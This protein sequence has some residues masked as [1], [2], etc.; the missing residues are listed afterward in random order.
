MFAYSSYNPTKK[1]VIL[2]TILICFLDYFFA[3]AAG[4]ICFGAI[5]AAKILNLEEQ[6]QTNG[7]GL[8]FVLFPALASYQEGKYKNEFGLFCFFLFLAGIDS[9]AAFMEALI[10]NVVEQFKWNRTISAL[11]VCL[12]GIGLSAIFCCSFG[13][14][15]FDLVEH[16][17]SSYTVI[18][19]GLMQVISVGWYFEKETTAAVSKGHADSLKWMGIIYWL[20]VVIVCFYSNFGLKEYSA[21][22]LIICVVGIF[23]SF[24]VSK[25]HSN[26]SMRSW[27]HEIVLCGVDKISMSITSLSSQNGE[28]E[29]W[30][31]PFEAY[32]GICIKFVC[33]VIFTWL[34]ADNLEQDL[35]RAYAEQPEKMQMFSSIIVF[36]TILL[37]FGPMFACDYPEIFEHDV[38]MEFNADNVYALEIRKK[39]QA[40]VE[41]IA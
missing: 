35:S 27:Y 41:K 34:I 8:A 31:F 7:V 38:N 11:V 15:L 24:A 3:I 37:I 32:F 6:N 23:L 14:V 26:M 20:T 9:A 36:I 1:P 33:P 13:W 19:V 30:M 39:T 5:G 10:T 12:L 22:G 28:R 40:S 17:L 4:F 29:W 18:G 2:D 16:Y 21:I 25:Y